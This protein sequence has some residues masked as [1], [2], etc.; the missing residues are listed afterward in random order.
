MDSHHLSPHLYFKIK[1]SLVQPWK[2]AKVTKVMNKAQTVLKLII[3]LHSLNNLVSK[4]LR[5]KKLVCQSVCLRHGQ[6][7]TDRYRL[8]LLQASHSASTL[9]KILAY[10]WEIKINFT[11]ILHSF[12]DLTW[13]KGEKKKLSVSKCCQMQTF[14]AILCLIS[15]LHLHFCLTATETPFFPFQSVSH[16]ES[17]LYK[18]LAYR[19]PHYSIVQDSGIQ[20]ST[21]P[22]PH[23]I[24]A[25][26]LYTHPCS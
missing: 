21:L 11:I 7:D 15:C 14:T 5:E 12:N 25:H 22:H 16:S 18:I 9:L 26:S 3:I 23:S 8:S 17:A 10:R 1:F 24:I 6:S 13:T 4:R 20:V 2:G 19:C